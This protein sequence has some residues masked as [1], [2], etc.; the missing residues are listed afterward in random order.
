MVWN[1]NGISDSKNNLHDII[2]YLNTF[3]IVML[4]ETRLESVDKDFLVGYSIA[5][6]PATKSGKAGQGILLGVKKSRH[7]H[8]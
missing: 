3:A 8:V 5:H 2:E 1:V 4:V 7:Y 6:I